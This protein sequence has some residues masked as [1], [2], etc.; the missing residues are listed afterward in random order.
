LAGDWSTV[1]LVPGDPG[2]VGFTFDAQIVEFAGGPGPSG[3]GA[4]NALHLTVGN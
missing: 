2:L 1:P 4:T 3:L